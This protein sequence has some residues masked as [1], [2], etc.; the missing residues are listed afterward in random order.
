MVG[1]KLFIMENEVI[2]HKADIR[3]SIDRIT[4]VGRYSSDRLDNDMREWLRKPFV[5]DVNGGSK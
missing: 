3:V 2:K 1:R 5:Q 4:I